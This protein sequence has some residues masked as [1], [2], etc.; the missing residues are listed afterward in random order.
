MLRCSPPM[1]CQRTTARPAGRP[2]WRPAP[3]RSSRRGRPGPPA[4]AS[5][6]T[7]ERAGPWWPPRADPIGVA[8][9]VDDPLPADARAASA[10]LGHV[11]S[12][13]TVVAKRSASPRARWLYQRRSQAVHPERSWTSVT[14]ASR[15]R[16]VDRRREVQRRR[17]PR[18]RAADLRSE[19]GRR[20][21]RA[22]G[23]RTR[24]SRPGCTARGG[25]TDGRIA[26]GAASPPPL[27]PTTPA[28][29]PRQPAWTTPTRRS[30][31]EEH[32]RRAVRR[33]H[34]EGAARGGR[35]GRVGVGAG[36]LARPGDDD[37]RRRRGPGAAT[38]TP[39]ARRARGHRRGRRRPGSSRRSW[40]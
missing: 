1:K 35:H 5:C 24:S 39:G 14:P 13:H 23:R 32:D 36:V 25:P 34:G 26:Q 18:G 11:S 2:P 8:A 6:T 15:Q 20:G 31:T 27:A 21:R 19:A 30:P 29:R 12:S 22:Q 28:T 9:G 37:H 33:A 4:T 3:A 40:G 38:S 7:R 16:G 10:R 17:A